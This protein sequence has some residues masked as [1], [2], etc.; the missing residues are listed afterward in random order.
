MFTII[1]TK[2]AVHDRLMSF[3][4]MQGYTMKD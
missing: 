3:R 1:T 2:Q 4:F